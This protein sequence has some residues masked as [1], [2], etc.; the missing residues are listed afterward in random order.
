[1]KMPWGKKAAKMTE[2][3]LYDFPELI[4]AEQA[5]MHKAIDLA[6]DVLCILSQ[7]KPDKR[8]SL[9]AGFTAVMVPP[10]DLYPVI[11]KAI[12]REPTR[13]ELALMNTGISEI[14]MTGGFSPCAS[15][16]LGHY[17][18]HLFWPGKE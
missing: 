9:G 8:Q 15:F 5:S 6:I 13:E 10:D 2:P 1:M 7:T 3:T 12:G 14:T 4:R 18:Q 16:S 17:L 11:V